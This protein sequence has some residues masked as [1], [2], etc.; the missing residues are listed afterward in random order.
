MST[1]FSFDTG[2]LPENL[3]TLPGRIDKAIKLA[4]EYAATKGSSQMKA[5]AP[6]TD[7]TGAARNGLHTKTEYTRDNYIIVFAH[8][9]WY[10]IYLETI[11]SGEY[12][13]IMPTIL[14]IRVD[15][16]NMLRGLINRV[17]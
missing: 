6:W 11:E 1:S 9:V 12:A 8:S 10:G 4:T 7:R 17:A 14:K 2:R 5:E 13:I 3:S 15:Y 16:M